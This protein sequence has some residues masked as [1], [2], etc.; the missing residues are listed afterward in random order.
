[1][2]VYYV[3]HTSTQRPSGGVK[4]IYR[5]VDIL[6]AAGI[7]AA[8]VH[9]PTD[10][11]CNWFKNNTRIVYPPLR[12]TDRDVL[13]YPE[14]SAAVMARTAPGVPKVS[15]CQNAYLALM[16]AAEVYKTRSDLRA[17]TA[18]SEQNLELMHYAFPRLEVDRIYLSINSSIF[19][20]VSGRRPHRIGYMPR[21]RESEAEQL[22]A[23]LRSRGELEGWE[24][25][26][27]EGLDERGVAEVLRTCVLFLSF[28][29][30]EGFGMPPLEALSCGC[31]VIGFSGFGG[32]EYFGGEDCQ[33]VPDGDLLAYAESVAG[34][35]ATYEARAPWAGAKA[36]AKCYL[37]MYSPDQEVRSV[38]AFWRKV[39]DTVPP[40]KGVSCALTKNDTAVSKPR[41]D[42]WLRLARTKRALF[43]QN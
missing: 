3:L 6:N 11:R 32:D 2:T 37:D 20:P 1:M 19:Y 42:W 30:R 25:I 7:D 5:H 33:Q 22:L 36:R 38:I 15:I 31:Q 26:R 27:I 29:Q 8:V 4:V 34:W 35:L 21:K 23:I 41:P 40:S 17:V 24:V 9:W 16:H 28:S 13:A 39:L 43:G 14:V 10:F 12:V 18:V